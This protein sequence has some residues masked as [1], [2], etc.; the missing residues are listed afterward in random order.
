MAGASEHA[1]NR[2]RITPILARFHK[3]RL[4]EQRFDPRAR[5]RTSAVVCDSAVLFHHRRQAHLRGAIATVA[6]RKEALH[7]RRS[8][9]GANAVASVARESRAQSSRP[10]TT[11]F[12]VRLFGKSSAPAEPRT[13]SSGAELLPRSSRGGVR[14]GGDAETS[15]RN[16]RATGIRGR[17]P[18][19]L[20]RLDELQQMRRS[21]YE[22][23]R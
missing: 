2:S 1:L 12:P 18:R 20:R 17:D 5:D 22:S 6:R 11:N 10:A 8:D 21:F 9:H 7:G 19:I 3:G 13:R 4:V 16:E 23:E 14:R 15:D